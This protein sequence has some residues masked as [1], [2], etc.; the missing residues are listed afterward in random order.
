[1]SSEMHQL[2]SLDQSILRLLMEGWQ[3]TEYAKTGGLLSP[4]EIAGQVGLPVEGVRER[5]IL[6]ETLGYI[7]NEQNYGADPTVTYKRI[8]HD[9]ERAP[10]PEARYHISEAGKRM[11]LADVLRDGPPS[12]AQP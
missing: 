8:D 11:V 12:E 9:R 10:L 7:T 3:T 5:L 2:E 6:L 4:E 1:V